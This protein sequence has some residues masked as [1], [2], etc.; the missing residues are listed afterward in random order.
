[1]AP[2]IHMAKAEILKLGIALGVPYEYTWS[3]YRNEKKA[4]GTCGSC[5]FRR[6][7]FA[8]IGIADPITYEG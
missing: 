3:C 8:A 5:H 6:G 1:M 2:F 4:C 7:A